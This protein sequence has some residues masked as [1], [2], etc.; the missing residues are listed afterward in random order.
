MTQNR[1]MGA[2]KALS[3]GFTSEALGQRRLLG[4]WWG[5]EHRPKMIQRKR[6]DE[7]SWLIEHTDVGILSVCRICYKIPIHALYPMLNRTVQKNR[8]DDTA[9]K[10]KANSDTNC[11]AVRK[12][13][14]SQKHRNPSEAIFKAHTVL[15]TYYSCA[16][17]KQ[18]LICQT[19]GDARTQ[20]WAKQQ[21]T[22]QNWVWFNMC[23][24]P[25]GTGGGAKAAAAGGWGAKGGV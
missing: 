21:R 15:D 23:Y 25:W 4:L 2:Y 10:V 1:N 11:S 12:H 24:L 3:V 18:D 8:T 20:V 7:H 16:E 6:W 19:A 5:A 17:I 22:S 14:R 13:L 9:N